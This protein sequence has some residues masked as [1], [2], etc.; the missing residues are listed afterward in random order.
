MLETILLVTAGGLLGFFIGLT[1]V[2]GGVLT[3]PT[4][5]LLMKLEPIAAVGTASLYAVLTKIWA[6]IQHYR[7][8]TINTA[9]GIRLFATIL[10]G[11][12]LGS[13]AIKWSKLSLPPSGIETLQQFVS[14]LVIVSIAFS[15]VALFCDYS[16]VENKF[17]ESRTGNVLKFSGLFLVGAIMGLTSIGGG[18]LLIPS[19]LLF[20]RE[21]TRYVGTSIFVAVLAMAVMSALYGFIGRNETVSDVNLSVAAWMSVGSLVGVHYGATLSKKI[22]P[23]RLQKMVIAV[24][25]LALVMMLVDRTL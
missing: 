10:P 5:I 18:I 25:V 13:V 24:I 15:L 2:G 20:Y 1:G 21:T 16:R 6:T 14:Y 19:L 9:V 23:Q 4:L 17:A 3:V 11:V 22:A 12:I 7:Q 8:G